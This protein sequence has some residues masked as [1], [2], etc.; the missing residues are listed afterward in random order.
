M[1]NEIELKLELDDAGA[2]AIVASGLH[3]QVCT[4]ARLH[5]SYFDTCDFALRGAGLS[6]RLRES[7]GLIIQTVKADG[8]ASAGL[9]DRAEWELPVSGAQPI[10]DPR[11]PVAALLGDR[12]GDLAERF[13]VAVERK[14]WRFTTRKGEIEMS[15]DCG[16]VRAAERCEHFCELELELIRGEPAT[17]FDLAKKIGTLAPVRIGMLTKPERGYRLLGPLPASR[18]AGTPRLDQAMPLPDAFALIAQHCIGHYRHNESIL[19]GHRSVEAVHQARIALRRLRSA[20]TLFRAM[21]PQP[22]TRH[23]QSRLRALADTLGEARDLDVLCASAGSDPVGERLATARE[24]AYARVATALADEDP[25][26]LMLDLLAWLLCGDWRHDRATAAVRAIT[27]GQ[28][29]GSA[30]DRAYRKVRKHSKH[31]ASLSPELRHEL[32]KDAKKLRYT[33]EFLSSL[34]PSREQTRQRKKFVKAFAALQ[35]DL[36]ALNDRGVAESYLGRLGLTDFAGAETFLARWD[37]SGLL[38]DASDTRNQLF[39][40]KPFWR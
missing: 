21:L 30:L 1:Q 22:E 20:L 38:K 13:T 28:F 3:R 40:L 18:K 5:S 9:F 2:D 32:R 23:F 39:D 24:E 37:Q 36:G 34:Y 14:T 16:E 17:L 6:L 33:I 15:L 35:D 8:P 11:T 4:A 25:R 19:L 26:R 27:P 12:S 31:L 10:A 7:D 29:A